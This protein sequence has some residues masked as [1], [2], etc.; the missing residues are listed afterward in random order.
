MELSTY[1]AGSA[2]T[3]ATYSVLYLIFATVLI[4]ANKHLI[5]ETSFNCPIFVSSL[6]SWF[7]W[8][9]AAVAIHTGMEPLSHKLTFGEW[10]ANILPIG[11]CTA[12]SLA[13]ANVA[14]FY[15]SLSFIQMLKA[16]APVVTYFTLVGFGLDRWSARI[17]STLSVVMF[18]CFIASWGEAHVTVFGLACMLAAEVAEAFRSVGIQY[19]IANKKFSLFNGMYYFSPATLVFL[20]AL[21]A[22]F[23]TEELLK[24]G[25]NARAFREYWY[26][27]A[28]CATFGFAVNYVCLGVVK[29]AGSLMVKTMSQLKNVVV[30]A[31]AVV[32]YGDDVSALEIFGYAVA[33]V[34]FLFFNHAKALDAAAVRELTKNT[35]APPLSSSRDRAA[36][37]GADGGVDDPARAPL[38]AKT[39]PS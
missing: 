3:A 23:E 30:I 10:C 31:A 36:P 34:G 21:S 28:I 15:L 4:L 2:T 25:E 17:M 5:T 37:G 29:H 32:I 16:F 27:F 1:G 14:Y 20:M 35:T 11:A 24:G 26:L 18:G 38:L 19:L 9:A 12:L 13:A 33:V 22:V 8:G 7:G 6:G 39:F